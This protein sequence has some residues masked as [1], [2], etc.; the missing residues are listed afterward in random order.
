MRPYLRQRP[1]AKTATKD[2]KTMWH[3]IMIVNRDQLEHDEE[4]H[5][6]KATI[7]EMMRAMCPLTPPR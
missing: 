7:S 6:H 1:P 3:H 2:A 5:H 4:E